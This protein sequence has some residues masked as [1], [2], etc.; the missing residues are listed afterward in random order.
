MDCTIDHRKEDNKKQTLIEGSSRAYVY[1]SNELTRKNTS[2][3]PKEN[4]FLLREENA[5]L[6][7]PWFVK[8]EYKYIAKYFV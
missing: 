2:L 4:G 7:L 3:G 1:G 8:N 6:N 5:Y